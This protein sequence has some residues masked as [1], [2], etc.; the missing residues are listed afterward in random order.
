MKKSKIE[1]YLD[2]HR[3]GNLGGGCYIYNSIRAC[4]IA[5]SMTNGHQANYKNE[6]VDIIF[7]GGL[8]LIKRCC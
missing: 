5:S 1:K 2:K 4:R 7:V 3:T 8:F 6:F